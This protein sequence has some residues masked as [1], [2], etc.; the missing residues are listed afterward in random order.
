[1][2][3]CVYFV[4]GECMEEKLKRW[5]GKR[6]QNPLSTITVG[7]PL[8]SHS[9]S[10]SLSLSPSLSLSLFLS[11]SL[12]LSEVVKYL[13][14]KGARLNLFTTDGSYNTLMIAA[15]HGHTQLVNG[16]SGEEKVKEKRMDD[17]KEKGK[18]KGKEK[19]IFS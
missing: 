12:S 13:H 3:V 19:P 18:E 16:G 7:P 2:C 4:K 5:K 1:M 17:K 11:L 8:L 6:K 10:L 15:M 9:L 14:G